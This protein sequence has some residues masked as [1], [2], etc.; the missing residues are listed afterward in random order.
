MAIQIVESIGIEDIIKS[1][2]GGKFPIYVKIT[3]GNNNGADPTMP[4]LYRFEY[5]APELSQIAG[6][7]KLC[8]GF[9]DPGISYF[10]ALV[11]R[12]RNIEPDIN[13]AKCL[14]KSSPGKMLVRLPRGIEF[15][16]GVGTFD[17]SVLRLLSKIMASGYSKFIGNIE[18]VGSFGSDLKADMA[19]FLPGVVYGDMF[20]DQLSK[21]HSVPITPN[22]TE[23]RGTFKSDSLDFANWSPK[24]IGKNKDVDAVVIEDCKSIPNFQNCKIEG[25]MILN[26]CDI[27][28]ARLPK[29]LPATLSMTG[30]NLK[31]L[32]EIPDVGN[33]LILSGN[34]DIDILSVKNRPTIDGDLIV[35]EKV[36][37]TGSV[38]R[39]EIK[40][41]YNIKGEIKELDDNKAKR[42]SHSM[43]GKYEIGLNKPKP[44][45]LAN[46]AMDVVDDLFGLA[47]STVAK[48]VYKGV[49]GNEFDGK[50]SY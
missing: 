21:N 46:M 40:N 47:G 30:C 8:V 12:S 13:E 25:S 50:K 17:R 31:L 45:E 11:F 2:G 15:K 38:T 4:H 39:D 33:D 29:K 22:T 28:F 20:F 1:T 34:P 19:L 7:E 37:K 27:D 43:S 48:T 49:T 14:E 24:L 6:M 36:L 35:S 26:D 41:K 3:N 42:N 9:K 32:G 18:I 44:S 16:S 10:V 23:I 5:D